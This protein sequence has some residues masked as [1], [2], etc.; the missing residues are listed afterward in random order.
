MYIMHNLDVCL[1]KSNYFVISIIMTSPHDLFVPHL[2]S[3]HS[4]DNRCDN[5]CCTGDCFGG[6]G[7][8]GGGR[9]YNVQ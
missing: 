7:G 6:G 1:Y 3:V 5:C 2:L 4:S 9:S 8:V